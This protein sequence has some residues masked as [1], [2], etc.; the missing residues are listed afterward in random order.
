MVEAVTRSIHKAPLLK[1]FH[2]IARRKK[3]P[4]PTL[5]FAPRCLH[6]K[7]PQAKPKPIYECTCLIPVSA[8]EFAAFTHYIFKLNTEKGF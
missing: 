5:D 6:D 7:K 3:Q 4:P 8:D 1:L 2:T